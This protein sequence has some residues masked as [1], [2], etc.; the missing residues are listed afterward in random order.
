VGVPGDQ[1]ELVL[2]RS[3]AQTGISVK[4][5]EGVLHRKIT[6]QVVNDY[7]TAI[8]SLNSGTPFM[9][10]K[11]DSPIGKA[12]TKLAREISQPRAEAAAPSNRL[13]AMVP[14]APALR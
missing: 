5:A 10:N 4:A 14:T 11:V 13:G 7:R 8:G 6:H 1:L 2:N 3:N 9:V 12:I